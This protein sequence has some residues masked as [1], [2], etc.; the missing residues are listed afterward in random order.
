MELAVHEESTWKQEIQIQNCALNP[1]APE[2]VGPQH[3]TCFQ[4]FT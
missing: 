4:H 1:Q 2:A 3:F